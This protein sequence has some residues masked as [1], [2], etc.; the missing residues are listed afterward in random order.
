M[1]CGLAVRG[2]YWFRKAFARAPNV[3]EGIY[4]ASARI[5]FVRLSFDILSSI[6]MYISQC[7]T[8]T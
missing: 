4:V 6:A 3:D 8:Y 2:S 7:F 5:V 1:L